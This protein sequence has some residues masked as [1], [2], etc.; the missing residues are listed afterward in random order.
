MYILCGVCTRTIFAVYTHTDRNLYYLL[1]IW[2]S[3]CI[4]IITIIIVLRV[5]SC[6]C[7]CSWSICIIMAYIVIVWGLGR[8]DRGVAWLAE[9]ASQLR[10][11]FAGLESTRKDC[12]YCY[13]CCCC[14]SCSCS[15]SNNCCSCSCSWYAW[16][17]CN[18]APPA[19]GG[20]VLSLSLS[21][22]RPHPF[23]P[24]MQFVLH[25][26]Q[27][28]LFEGCWV[29]TSYLAGRQRGLQKKKKYR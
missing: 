12:P 17:T 26:R 18:Y 25:A 5:V 27:R 9:T 10:V 4:I 22:S 15:S 6:S 11:Q 29:T 1:L 8:G 28:K 7:S 2:G 23:S 16:L 24:R 14:C 19:K 20:K 21:H 3:H 13:Y